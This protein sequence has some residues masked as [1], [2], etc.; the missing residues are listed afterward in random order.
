MYIKAEDI[1]YEN[2]NWFIKGLM[3]D[4]EI[5]KNDYNLIGTFR[6]K[7]KFVIDNQYTLID[8]LTRQQNKI[9]IEVSGELKELKKKQEQYKSRIDG[10]VE[11]LEEVYKNH[12]NSDDAKA[13]HDDLKGDFL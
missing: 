13:I 12:Y 5:L 1:K 4:T 9:L 6:N 2:G 3:I 10:R 8:C 11:E 7:E